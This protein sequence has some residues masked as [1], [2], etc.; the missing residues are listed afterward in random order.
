MFSPVKVPNQIPDLVAR[1]VVGIG[2]IV[3]VAGEIAVHVPLVHAVHAD[4]YPEIIF[5][6]FIQVVNVFAHD[7]AGE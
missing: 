5:G 2:G 1:Y 3:A 7:H 6:V 4:G